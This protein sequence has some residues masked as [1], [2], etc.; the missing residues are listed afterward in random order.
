M[1]VGSL[2]RSQ[3]IQFYA[4]QRSS[5]Q[6]AVRDG[7]TPETLQ[8]LLQD[9]RNSIRDEYTAD[10]ARTVAQAGVNDQLVADGGTPSRG[11]VAARSVAFLEA[12]GA[13]KVESE[14]K[15]FVRQLEITLDGPGDGS[16]PGQKSL[17]SLST[18]PDV[19]GIAMSAGSLFV[20][21]KTPEG[22]NELNAWFE[23]NAAELAE[24]YN[25]RTLV[26]DQSVSTR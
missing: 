18:M 11:A 23:A 10:W 12:G 16:R 4:T 25:V 9:L 21:L 3:L 5:L 13:L 19:V 17:H 20:T 7:A 8:P 2:S 1:T 26:I 14:L 22:K 15:R 6:R 24:G